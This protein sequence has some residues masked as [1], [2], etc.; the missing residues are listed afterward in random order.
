VTDEEPAQRA[1]LDEIGAA[2]FVV[3]SDVDDTGQDLTEVN[4][5]DVSTPAKPAVGLSLDRVAFVMLPAVALLLAAGAGYLK[6]EYASR[7]DSQ[8]AAAESVTAAADTAA[9]ILSYR[10]DSV[11]KDLSAARDRLTGSFLESYTTLV[12]DVVIPGAK[13]KKITAVAQVPA[14]ASV[15][16]TPSHAVV[17]VFVNQATTIGNDPTT[18]TASSVRVTLDKI[19]DRWLVSGFDPI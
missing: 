5:E 18:N 4:I 1:E 7:Q 14:A 2:E 17:L 12:N 9:A 3:E 11:D 6:W 16:A 8:R 15:S 10:P 13:Q 19:G